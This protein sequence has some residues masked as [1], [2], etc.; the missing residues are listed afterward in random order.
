[1]LLKIF[2]CFVLHSNTFMKGASIAQWLRQLTLVPLGISQ[3]WITCEK[4]VILIIFLW[5]IWISLR[6][7][8][9]HNTGKSYKTQNPK[10]R[11][12]NEK[13]SIYVCFPLSW[14]F[15][16]DV[17]SDQRLQNAVHWAYTF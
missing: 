3:H 6:A 10:K 11:R 8:C 7:L 2:G 16:N 9:S 17:C 1:M 4:A 13:H 15:T 5:K 12:N 14:I